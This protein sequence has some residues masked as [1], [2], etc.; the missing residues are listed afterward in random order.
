MDVKQCTAILKE[1]GISHADILFRGDY[2]AD[3]LIDVV[4][5]NRVYL[6]A[7]Y[8]YNKCDLVSIEECDRLAHLPDSM[9]ASCAINLNFDT[10]LAKV[11]EYLELVRVYT[12]KRGAK[13]IWDDPVVLRQG[14][15]IKDVCHGVHKS[16]VDE[17]KAGLVWGTS[18]KH[19]PQR[20]A[21]THQVNDED[22]VMIM[23]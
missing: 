6:R 10:L 2:G 9:V 20:V 11:W 15:T 5:G 19:S 18:A 22:V 16:L 14:A 21:I 3:E 7:L 13:P 1:F 23:K 8:C 12:K 17:F 4:S